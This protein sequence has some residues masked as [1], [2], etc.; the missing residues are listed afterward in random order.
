VIGNSS[1]SSSSGGGGG[2]GGGGGMIDGSHLNLS[3]PALV[4]TLANPVAFAA[5]PVST[6]VPAQALEPVPAG[7][8]VNVDATIHTM[9]QKRATELAS[10]TTHQLPE[11]SQNGKQTVVEVPDLAQTREAMQAVMM[12]NVLWSP[13]ESGPW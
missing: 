10:Y 4:F 12:W 9:S 3:H 2:G 6:P 13:S 7:V 8:N 5:A 1:N 11:F